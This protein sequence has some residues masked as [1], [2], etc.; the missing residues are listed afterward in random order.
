MLTGLNYFDCLI[1]MDDVVVFSWNVEV[2]FAQLDR[3]FQRLR[4]HDLIANP[5]KTFLLQT[6]AKT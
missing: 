3:V 6:E 5:A 1:Y 2:L 4:E